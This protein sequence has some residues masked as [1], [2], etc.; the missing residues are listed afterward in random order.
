MTADEKPA[1]SRTALSR[2]WLWVL[3]AVVVIA[4][5]LT[6]TYLEESTFLKVIWLIGAGVALVAAA[7]NLQ[8]ALSARRSG[9]PSS[10]PPETPAAAP[11][12]LP[13]EI[14]K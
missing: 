8:E 12:P 10:P 2:A 3:A 13:K 6:N 5:C 9:R 7:L 14:D 1:T 4:L 11:E